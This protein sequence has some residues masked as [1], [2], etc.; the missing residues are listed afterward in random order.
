MLALFG[1]IGLA[2]AFGPDLLTNPVF[3]F[4]FVWMWVGLVPLSLIMGPVWRVVNPLRTL[5]RR[6]LPARTDRP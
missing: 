3:G 2:V 4:V 1:W 5:H 6:A